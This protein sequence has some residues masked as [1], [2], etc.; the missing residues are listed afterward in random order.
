VA[1]GGFDRRPGVDPLEHA[2]HERRGDAEITVPALLGHREQL[3]VHELGEMAARG[4]RRHMGEKGE[5]GRGQG[6]PVHER[7]QD[8]GARRIP[9]QRRHFRHARLAAHA[10]QL[11]AAAAKFQAPKLRRPPKRSRAPA[12]GFGLTP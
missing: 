8:I 7:P 6:A 5:F 3:A 9:H 11:G 12:G 4:L 10:R 2:R 1:R